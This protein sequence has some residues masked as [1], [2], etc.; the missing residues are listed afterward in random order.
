MRS[1]KEG[2]PINHLNSALI[3]GRIKV[4]PTLS[5]TMIGIVTCS[6]TV[7]NE[8]TYMQDGEPQK[9][10]SNFEVYAYE[11]LTEVWAEHLNEGRMVRVVG[12]LKQDHSIADKNE[13]LSKVYIVAEHI[14]FRSEM[15]ERN[16]ENDA[17]KA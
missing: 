16:K 11:R 13:P 9:E 7:E 8:R 10:V 3:E 1:Q 6:F 2:R 4:D 12:R 17:I 15:E 5:H 14:E